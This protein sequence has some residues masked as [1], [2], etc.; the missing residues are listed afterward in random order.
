MQQGGPAAAQGH[1]DT[2][3]GA[4]RERQRLE[5]KGDRLKPVGGHFWAVLP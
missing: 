4:P 2:W 3:T 1:E 5:Q